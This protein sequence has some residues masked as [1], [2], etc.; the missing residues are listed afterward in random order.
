[1]MRP[2]RDEQDDW[3]SYASFLASSA[4]AGLEESVIV[5][6]HRMME[7]V[8]RLIGLVP[9]L[10]SQPFFRD[11]ET[12]LEESLTEAYL[13]SPEDFA[14]LLD[15]LLQRFAMEARIRNQLE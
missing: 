11:L 3:F 2:V 8:R 4:R 15:E 5:S 13:K 9:E 6:G 12:T 7:A 1:M 14:K 10:R